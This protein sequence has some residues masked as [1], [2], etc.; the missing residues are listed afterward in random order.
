MD[1]DDNVLDGQHRL[2]AVIQAEKP[3][4]IMLGRNLNPSIFNVVDIGSKRTAGDA[5]EIMGS[6]KGRTIAVAL[7]TTNFITSFQKLN[8]QATI[9]LNIVR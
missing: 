5:L 8:G 3:I 6:T 9:L 2:E 4:Q 7:K 1:S